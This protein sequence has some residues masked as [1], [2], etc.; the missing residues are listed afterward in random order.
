M[1]NEIKAATG[2][3]LIQWAR[4]TGFH[5]LRKNTLDADEA[6]MFLTEQTNMILDRSNILHNVLDLSNKEAAGK[7]KQ[8][9]QTHDFKTAAKLELIDEIA[10]ASYKTLRSWARQCGFS[11]QQD[12]VADVFG[13]K[14]F[15]Q[16]RMEISFNQFSHQELEDMNTVDCVVEN[17]KLYMTTQEKLAPKTFCCKNLAKMSRVAI[18]SPVVIKLYSS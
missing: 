5:L 6:R 10:M 13:F 1:I 15:L 14:S 3:T 11:N 9:M 12:H 18:R 17:V 8:E 2:R 4:K 7:I 16:A